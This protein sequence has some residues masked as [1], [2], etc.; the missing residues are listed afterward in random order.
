MSF[1]TDVKEELFKLLPHERHCRLSELTAILA[2]SGKRVGSSIFVYPTTETKVAL[3]K[4]F[5]LL[6]KTF[7]INT[8]ILGKDLE[9]SRE[10]IEFSRDNPDMVPVLDA[11]AGET[12]VNLLVNDC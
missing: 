3:R 9:E 4:C 11:I 1:S 5:T 2:F 10:F 6:S 12:P 7:N 8:D